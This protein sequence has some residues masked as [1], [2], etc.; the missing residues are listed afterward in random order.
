[1][2]GII[3]GIIVIPFY[4]AGASAIGTA[5]SVY[6]SLVAL[7]TSSTECLSGI[8]AYEAIANIA[9]KGR[10]HSISAFGSV[11]LGAL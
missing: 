2:T 9:I 6:S 11:V 5:L 3:A 1:M 8:L 10:V 4:A 7:T